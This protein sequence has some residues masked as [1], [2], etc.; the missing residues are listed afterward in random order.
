MGLDNDYVMQEMG[1]KK[2]QNCA[3][4]Q[5]DVAYHHFVWDRTSWLI[6]CRHPDCDKWKSCL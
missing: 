2:S 3:S 4:C 5:H 6:A 1:Y